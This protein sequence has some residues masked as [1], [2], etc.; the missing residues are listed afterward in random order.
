MYNFQRTSKK[1]STIHSKEPS[2][3]KGIKAASNGE[4]TILETRKKNTHT[5]VV[6]R[7]LWAPVS[8][9]E[10]DFFCFF[11]WA[12]AVKERFPVKDFPPAV[13]VRSVRLCLSGRSCV[14]KTDGAHELLKRTLASSIE[15]LGWK[16]FVFFGPQPGILGWS[17]LSPN[18]GRQQCGSVT[19]TVC[20]CVCV[21]LVRTPLLV[22]LAQLRLWSDE[23]LWANSAEAAKDPLKPIIEPSP[24]RRKANP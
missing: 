12:A 21:I 22:I 6:H 7:T 13:R 9:Q 15:P 17:Q 2:S 20:V 19:I 16:P 5:H 1:R 24:K 23:Y 14:F 4:Q 10:K 8:F 3:L 11:F 18:S